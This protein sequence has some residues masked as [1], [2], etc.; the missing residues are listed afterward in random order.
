MTT[1]YGQMVYAQPRIPKQTMMHVT[2]FF[3]LTATG[4]VDS[5]RN[6]EPRATIRRLA[7][8]NERG[9]N[10][11]LVFYEK[12][13][14]SNRMIARFELDAFKPSWP[15]L[16]KPEVLIHADNE[17][18]FLFEAP[19]GTLILVSLVESIDVE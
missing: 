12:T 8:F 18:L 2:H 6:R 14:G 7:A 19:P 9:L 17:G 11:A 16:Y 10:G 13:E 1:K 3:P 5:Y 15:A 4:S